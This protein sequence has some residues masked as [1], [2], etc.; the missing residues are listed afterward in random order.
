MVE[1]L[2]KCPQT[3]G[4][5]WTPEADAWLKEAAEKGLYVREAAEALGVSQNVASARYRRIYKTTYDSAKK[6]RDLDAHPIEPVTVKDRWPPGIYFEDIP[7]AL[8]DREIVKKGRKY[9]PIGPIR[10]IKGAQRAAAL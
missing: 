7:A 5:H 9:P 6:P 1:K 10:S 2:K 8:L 4:W 3:R